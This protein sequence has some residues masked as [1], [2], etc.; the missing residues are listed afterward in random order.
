MNSSAIASIAAI[1]FNAAPVIF[2]LV[3]ETLTERAGVI[4]LSLNGSILLTAMVGFAV[5]FTTHS[6]IAGFLAAAVV[7]ALVALL[8]AFFSI[9]LKQSQ[10]AVGYVLTL[11]CKSLAY[12]LGTPFLFSQVIQLPLMKIPLLSDIPILGPI[13]F[14]QNIMVYFSYILIVVAFIWIFRTRGG[15]VLRGVGERPAAAFVRGANVNRIR[16]IYTGIGGAL[17]G[18]SGAIYSLSVKPGWAG[19]TSGLDG[20]GWII[21]A[22]TIFGGWNP[23]RG[24]LGAYLF[25]FLQQLGVI[26]QQS[27]PNINFRIFQVAPFPLM[28]LTL[29]FVNIGDAEWVQRTLAGLP[30]DA[31]RVIAGILRA[32]RTRPPAALGT[33]F[34]NE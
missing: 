17:V 34:E 16:Y 20:F 22:I 11:T 32:M 7:G 21:L 23:I 18:I 12:F 19:Q 1:F 14:S 31:R 10:V 24:A 3:G 9:T 4:N 28:I 33:P 26:L 2:A 27:L 13:L 6:F 8:I 15:L 29:L 30:E 25:A 5:A